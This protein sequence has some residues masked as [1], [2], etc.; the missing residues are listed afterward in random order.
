[1]RRIRVAL[2]GLALLIAGDVAEAAGRAGLAAPSIYA[3]GWRDGAPAIASR[4]AWDGGSQIVAEGWRWLGQANPTGTI[5][6]WCA[7]FASFVL[8]RV[9]LPPLP[10]RMASSALGYGRRTNAPQPGDLAVMPHHVGFVAGVEPDGSIDLL[11]GNYS[12]RVALARVPRSAFVAFV[13][14]GMGAAPRPAGEVVHPRAEAA[15][16]AKVARFRHAVKRP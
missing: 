11:S 6:P 5:G 1:M 13:D 4:A 12:R 3:P 8:R 15:A 16:K 9:G 2:A 14:V 7:D 10:N